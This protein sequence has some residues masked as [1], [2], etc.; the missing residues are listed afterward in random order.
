MPAGRP[1][2]FET[3][4]QMEAAITEFVESTESDKTVTGLAIHL[5]FES[6]Q[7]MYDYLK[8]PEFSYLINKALLI[9]ENN[10]EKKACGNNA[11][12]PIF[13]LKNMGWKDKHET[14]HS[15]EMSLNW[16][17][18]RNYE[19]NPEANGGAGHTGG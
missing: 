3:P 2:I 5:G 8:K 9:V 10:Y 13:V 16:N 7:S 15:G 4:E 14:E 6:R 18:T 1:P 11:A 19:P 17:E 12:G